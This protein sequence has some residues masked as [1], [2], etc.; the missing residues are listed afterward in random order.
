MAPFP[1]SNYES[2]WKAARTGLK[3]AESDGPLVIL[4]WSPFEEA[5]I[6]GPFASLFEAEEYHSQFLI[7]RE[8]WW[9]VPLL[10]EATNVALVRG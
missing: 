6:H 7:G 3:Q 10:K 8:W 4:A 5:E 9:Y 2:W 1:E